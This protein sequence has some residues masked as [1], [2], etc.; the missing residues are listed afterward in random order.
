[1]PKYLKSVHNF[2]VR[3]GERSFVY[4]HE[5]GLELTS[6]CNFVNCEVRCLQRNTIICNIIDIP[7]LVTLDIHWDLK[8]KF[9]D[10]R[11]RDIELGEDA[12]KAS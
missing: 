4:D 3:R 5:P 7:P 1:M 12:M 9:Q 11:E 6:V 8:V 10:N 2:S